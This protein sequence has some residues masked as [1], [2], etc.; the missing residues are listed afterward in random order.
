VGVAFLDLR[1]QEPEVGAA[2]RE[3]V[4]EVLATQQ[5]VLGPQVRRFEEAMAAWCRVPHAV[6]VGSGTDALVLALRALGVRPGD[7][8]LTTPFSFFATASTIARVGAVPVFADVDP[9]TLNLDPDAAA[10]VL[11]TVPGVVGIVPVH[12]FGRLADMDRLG[13][14]AASHGCWLLEDA[15][16]AVGARR[17]GRAAGTLGRAGAVSFYPT[18]NLGGIGDGGMV[19]TADDALASAVRRDGNQGLVA[20]YVHETLGACSRLDAIQAAALLAKLPHLDGWNARRRAVADRYA[21]GFR[22]RGLAGGPDA[23]LVLPE[24]DGEAHVFHVYCVRARRRDAL[25]A[26][27][28]AA[29]VATQVYYRVPLHRQRALAERVLVPC[30]VPEAERAADEVLALPIYPQLP[31]DAVARVV[32]A[33]AAFF[34][35]DRG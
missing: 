16:Q 8:V 12:L 1:A 22:A 21:A 24:P 19:L 31:A 5:C 17:G 4:A 27:L 28:Q 23:P 14:L 13:A 10:Q 29:G 3:A 11:A 7:R 18:K 30:G 35:A 15:A 2:V 33:V 26:H 6:G 20:P 9:A 34:A 32:D 25:Q